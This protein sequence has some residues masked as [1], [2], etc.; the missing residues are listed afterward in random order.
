MVEWLYRVMKKRI[1]S[2]S[3]V[4]LCIAITVAFSACSSDDEIKIEAID[5]LPDFQYE[6][7]PITKDVPETTAIETERTTAATVNETETSAKTTVSPTT[8]NTVSAE[9]QTQQNEN[10]DSRM[11]YITPSGKRYH[12]SSTCGGKNSYSVSINNVGD[13]TPCKK[14]AQ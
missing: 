8:D 11:V 13:R 3:V 10:T 9:T 14:C 1:K 4:F 2:I 5:F 12:Y 7:E 6:S